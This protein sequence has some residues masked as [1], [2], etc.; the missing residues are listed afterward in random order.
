VT[1]PAVAVAA[2]PSRGARERV[3]GLDECGQYQAEEQRKAEPTRRQRWQGQ[4]PQ[5]RVQRGEREAE[6]GGK[7]AEGRALARA[8]RRDPTAREREWSAVVLKQ[9]EKVYARRRQSSQGWDFV[10]P[11]RVVLVR[12]HHHRGVEAWEEGQMASPLEKSEYQ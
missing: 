9:R 10:E 8:E 3:R 12:P 1:L 4:L 11:S 6:E 2:R 7:V 5:W